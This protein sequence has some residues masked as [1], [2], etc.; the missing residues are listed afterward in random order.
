MDETLSEMVLIRKVV[1][2]VKVSAD[3]PSELEI[4]LVVLV[5]IEVDDA[6]SGPV[7]EELDETVT[8]LE[9]ETGELEPDDVLR[10]PGIE[11]PELTLGDKLEKAAS[12]VEV[13]VESTEIVAVVMDTKVIG[14]GPAVEEEEVETGSVDVAMQ[15][16]P[17]EILLG[18]HSD[19]MYVGVPITTPLV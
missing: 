1:K 13:E 2:V 10:T 8:E 17:L 12:S 9:S 19:G 11:L 14:V 16:H 5:S 6:E 7:V 3:V 15:L 4:T 18:L